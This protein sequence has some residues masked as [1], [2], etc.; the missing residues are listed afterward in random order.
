V[1]SWASG[2]TRSQARRIVAGLEKFR[3]IE[4]DFKGID[5]IGQAFADEIFR[6]Y[7]KE[8][9]FVNIQAVGTTE[10]IDRM[11]AHALAN[12]AEMIPVSVG[13]PPSSL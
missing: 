12:R 4:L 11:I 3:T 1:A 7:A 10:E 5:T 8:H 9:P 13:S 6:V 2:P